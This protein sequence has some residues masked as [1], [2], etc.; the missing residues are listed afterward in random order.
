MAD[1]TPPTIAITSNKTA[2]K[3]GDTA[4]IT[5]TLSEVATD[6]VLSDITVSGG[7]LSNFSGS[8]STYSAIFTPNAKSNASGLVY[9]GNYKFS[10]PSGNINEDGADANNRVTFAIDTITPSISISATLIYTV[11]DPA[12]I[13]FTLTEPSTDF[14]LSDVSVNEGVLSNFSGSETFYRA[15]FTPNKNTNL[16]GIVYV[17][18]SK[19]S[20]S[21]GNVNEDG[22][23]SNNRV[24]I[25]VDK[26]APTI[27]IIA[28]KTSL[29][30]NEN[31]QITFTLSEPTGTQYQGD[32]AQ[33]DVTVSGGTLSNWSRF[34]LVYK[35]TFTPD[36]NSN[37]PGLVAVGDNKF[38]DPSGNLNKDGSDLNNRVSFTIDTK[39]PSVKISTTKNYLAL[40]ETPSITFS[41]SELSTNF[42]LSD[43]KVIN[44]TLS[45]FNGSGTS[46]SAILTPTGASDTVVS[47]LAD[48]FTD[49]IGNNNIASTE[50][51]FVTYDSSKTNVAWT[52]L[53][54]N[55][56]AYA[57]TTGLDGS[58]YVSGS[59]NA[60]LDGQNS[61]GLSDAFLTKYNPDGTKAWT[62]L[63]GT[64]GNDCSY[65][66]TTGLD[67]SIFV[68]GMTPGLDIYGQ[69]KVGL[70][71]AFLTKYNSDG[72][73]GWTRVLGTNTSA[74]AYALKTGL[75]GSIYISGAIGSGWKDAFVTKYSSDGTKAWTQSFG[76]D[77]FD[78][79][80]YALTTG[81]DGAIYVS[82][83]SRYPYRRYDGG[84]GHMLNSEAFVAKFNKD[85][86][87][88][89]T[90][91]LSSVNFDGARAITVG[92]DGSIYVSGFT[93]GW[94]D[95]LTN[96]GG[97]FKAGPKTFP[98]NDAFI[99]KY[100]P[101]GTQAWVRLLG[102]PS[103]DYAYALTT[104]LDG[105][106]YVG[107]YTNA[108]LSGQT[109]NG[110]IDAFVAKYNPNGSL[111]WTQQL[112]SSGN[113]YGLSLTTGLDG[114]IY[115]A[116]YTDSSL[117]G[118]SNKGGNS[119]FLMKLTLPDTS[120]PNI[121]VTSNSKSLSS[122]QTSIIT[123]TL[124]KA[125]TT[126]TASDVTVTGGTLSSFTGSETSYSALFTPTANSTS[127]GVVRVASGVFTDVAGNVNADGSDANNSVTLAVDTLLPTIA[128]S[129]NKSS[130]Q[131]GDSATLTFTLSEASTNFAASDI[132]VAGG[133]LSNFTGS[134]TSYTATFTLVAISAVTGSVNVSNGVFTDTAGNKNADGS[135]SNNAVSFARIPTITNKI[136]T[137]SVIVDKN[138]LGP[139]AVLLKGLKESMTITNGAITK[140]I[141]E[142]AGSTFNYDQIDSLITIVT[143]DGE[144][145][146]EFT[147]E[148]N[149]YLGTEQNIT[150]S[151]AVALVGAT[152]IDGVILSV[153][154]AD[155]NFA[156]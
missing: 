74:E 18:N 36:T 53:L 49:A 47:I 78:D 28:D 128:V 9:V 152:S 16:P 45:S 40:N 51:R 43:I 2:L 147:K 99:A 77:G 97:N 92:L 55:S 144:F 15:T 3:A 153:A 148:I 119:A 107:G 104:G 35:A 84:V 102:T 125:S 80:A 136:H 141:V 59:T 134:G 123:F 133:T 25:G 81:L 93:S 103:Q 149:D 6:L 12:Q 114:S 46:Y 79:Y 138:V 95:E 146:A 22:L 135:D 13:T 26:T 54:E 33:S 96:S 23:D 85:G 155:G 105:S 88:M 65:A 90:Q 63:M 131:G 30:A 111:V 106:I 154:G 7:S 110:G 42:D 69:T 132:T 62:R 20:D 1:T 151:A 137:L 41:L 83:Y 112:G 130:L 115:L 142:Y 8:G 34:G 126:F 66:L 124:S 156:G 71:D 94:F 32:F 75:D 139:D 37:V 60:S 118:Q 98:S 120:P 143:R 150:Y 101:D 58:I 140:H 57:L 121:Q 127:I 64:V 44:G 52:R 108:W 27:E 68:G 31:A 82:G 4:L 19:F 117:D 48:R 122:S 145:T 17:G 72:S 38:S 129:S 70:Y 100:T 116:G 29:K 109:G 24:S 50:M 56:T 87:N 10:D 39:P 61:I 89:W 73:K 76:A 91:Y 21:S 11:G 113:D 5:F 86:T 67:G 14:D